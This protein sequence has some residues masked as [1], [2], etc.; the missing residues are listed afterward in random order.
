MISRVG[1]IGVGHLASYLVQGLRRASRDIEIVLSPR[2]AERSAYLTDRFGATVA[3]SNQAVAEAADLVLLTTRPADVLEVCQEIVFVPEQVVVSVAVGLPLA[4]LLP[5][6][7]PATAVRVLPIS[8]AAINRSPTLLCPDH[9]QVKA[10]FGL[11][12]RVHVLSDES[13]FTAASV[14]SAFYG[15]VYALEGEVVRWTIGA[16]VEPPTARNL[17]LE[18]V[19]GAAEMALAHPEQD[20]TSMLEALATPGGITEH[21]LTVLDQ[22]QGLEVWVK[23]LESVYCRLGRKDQG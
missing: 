18:T 3:T 10:L 4:D 7:A 13:Q 1:V 15:W 17:V 20:L 21:G 14:L 8:C 23:A 5:V 16:G 11:L 22:G 9:P 2:N 19:R 6:V 12:G